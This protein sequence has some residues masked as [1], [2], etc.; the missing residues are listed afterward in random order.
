MMPRMTFKEVL[1]ARWK[2]LGGLVLGLAGIAGGLALFDLLKTQMP[3]SINGAPQAL[4]DQLN[5]MTASF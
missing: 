1:E 5:L 2:F 3:A 4:Q